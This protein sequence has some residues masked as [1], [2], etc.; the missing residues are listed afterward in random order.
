MFPPFK[1]AVLPAQKSSYQLNYP[2]PPRNGV[3]TVLSAALK[4]SVLAIAHGI[5]HVL[6]CSFFFSVIRCFL[7]CGSQVPALAIHLPLRRVQY[8][9]SMPPVTSASLRLNNVEATAE[10]SQT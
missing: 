3:S 2:P 8:A 10:E 9:A 6:V 4:A 5:T 7:R 1:S